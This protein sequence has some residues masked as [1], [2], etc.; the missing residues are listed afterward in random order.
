MGAARPGSDVDTALLLSEEDGVA[1]FER[2]LWLINEVS[3]VCEREVDVIVLNDAPP[4]LQHQV[5]KHRRLLYERGSGGAGR[6][7]GV[8]W[9]G[10]RGIVNKSGCSS[11]RIHATFTISSRRISVKSAIM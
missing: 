1:R 7:R 9:Q 11:R 10:L 2:R 8:G 6:V 3:D 5:L 4:L